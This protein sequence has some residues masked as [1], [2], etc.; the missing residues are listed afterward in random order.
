[1]AEQLKVGVGRVDITPP[2]GTQLMGYP[3][4]DRPAERVRDPLYVTTLVFEQGGRKA[5]I[6]EMDLCVVDN[7]EYA[8]I[9]Q[10]VA[11][12]VGVSVGQVI[13]STI[14]TH[15]GPRTQRVW[16]WCDKDMPY[17][18]SMIPKVIESAA[19]ANASLQP[20]K[21]GIGTTRS[22]VGVNRRG[23]NENGE[24]GLNFNPW[25][26]IDS[27]MTV[28]RIENDSGKPI[29]TIVHHGAHPTVFDGRTRVISRDWP[30]VMCDRVEHFSSGAPCLY[31]NGAV[32]DIA[33]RTNF[34]RAVGDGEIALMEVGTRAASDA[35]T[36][37][38]SI[39][40]F[41][42]DLK[43]DTL[44]ETLTLP[45]RP[46]T[47]LDEA[48]KNL[49]AAEPNKENYGQGM[50]DYKHWRA[51]VEAHG[52]APKPSRPYDQVI[53]R[54]G[55]V[56]FVPFP[57]EPFAETILRLRQFSPFENTLCISTA[58]NNFG[59]FPTREAFARGGYECWVGR[60]FGPYLLAE[61]CDDVLVKENLR[62]LRKMTN[63]E[64]RMT[65][66]DAFRHSGIRHS[67]SIIHLDFGFSHSSLSP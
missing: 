39:R 31:L 45:H 46:L 7:E 38:R 16:G 57:G 60:A 23:V 63:D 26:A 43:L 11:K 1:M 28:V 50:C 19:I 61:N 34:Q 67:S 25:G 62:L 36:A 65:N 66:E 4:P 29:A 58:M 52:Q 22:E 5:V 47:P 35:M 3:T 41:R 13:A 40:D 14:Q 10:G 18:E 8:Q 55:P 37:Y 20:A 51:V 44:A 15:S 53:V 24:I 49:A 56:A 27:E 48:R 42:N 6:V 64:T 9:R 12:R 33:P 21:I 32:G 2:V 54:L 59:Y 17:I 30:G